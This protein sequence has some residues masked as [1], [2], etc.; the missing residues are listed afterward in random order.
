VYA[1]VNIM[2]VSKA[3]RPSFPWRR[4]G[5][6][7]NKPSTYFPA[8]IEE[9]A[10]GVVCVPVRVRV[11]LGGGGWGK[12]AAGRR[13]SRLLETTHTNIKMARARA[14]EMIATAVCVFFLPVIPNGHPRILSRHPR[15]VYRSALVRGGGD[16]RRASPP[17]PLL[18]LCVDDNPRAATQWRPKEKHGTQRHSRYV[19]QARAFVGSCL[20]L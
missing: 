20:H 17:S 12:N 11:D 10:A 15:P 18:C 14:H 19:R 2:A 9:A 16:L 4:S 1:H 8:T 7:K 6:K 5:P 13:A 3:C